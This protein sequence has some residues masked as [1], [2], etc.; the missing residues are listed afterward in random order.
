M[1]GVHLKTDSMHP[2][3]HLILKAPLNM[4][5]RKQFLVLS[6]SR[7]LLKFKL[8]IGEEDFFEKHF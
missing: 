5:N 6:E 2:K 4:L 1:V 7:I 3:L 8:E